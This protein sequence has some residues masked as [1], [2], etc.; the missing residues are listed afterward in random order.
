MQPPDEVEGFE[1]NF[2]LNMKTIFSSAI[3][4][5]SIFSATAQ[6]L[7]PPEPSHMAKG[8]LKMNLTDFAVG[9][10]SMSYERMFSGWTTAEL[11]VS[12]IGMTSRSSAYTIARPNY[13]YY[14]SYYYDYPIPADIELVY[15]GWEVTLAGRKYGW[16]DQGIPDGFYASVFATVGGVNVTA[17]EDIYELSFDP[18]TVDWSPNTY[19]KEID[20]TLSVK[21]WGFGMLLGYQMLAANGL[22]VDAYIG[23]MFRG[24]TRTY[25]MEGQTSADA[26]DI[27]QRRLNDHYFMPGLNQSTYFANTGPWFAGGIR[28]SMAF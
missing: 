14:D 22:G 9:K 20:H 27:V 21:K 24:I 1:C 25:D 4:A 7:T 10:Y 18:D 23:P 3:L 15:S 28:V 19:V 2:V 8:M 6:T 12:G 26:E 13:D 5:I 11:T 17:D 16:V